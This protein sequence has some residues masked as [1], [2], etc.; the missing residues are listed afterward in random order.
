MAQQQTTSTRDEA[1]RSGQIPSEAAAQRLARRLARLDIPGAQEAASV[2]RRNW[3]AVAD[4][5]T[6]P[7]EMFDLVRRGEK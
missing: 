7:A 4:H 1:A 2:L 3:R 6:L 5:P